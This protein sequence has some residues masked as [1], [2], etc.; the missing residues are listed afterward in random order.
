MS[1]SRVCGSGWLGHCDGVGGGG[2]GGG[3]VNGCVWLMQ[4]LTYLANTV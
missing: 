3:G 4:Y 2:G 1:G